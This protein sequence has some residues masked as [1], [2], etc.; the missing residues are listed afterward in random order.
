MALSYFNGGKHFEGGV[1][2]EDVYGREYQGGQAASAYVQ[3][4]SHFGVK[5][6]PVDANQ[7]EQLVILAHGH[8]KAGHAVILSEIDPYC[9][10][11]QRDVLGWSHVVI[12]YAEEAGSITVADPFI[13]QSV[14]KSDAEWAHDLMFG[15]IWIFE[16]IQQEDQ[17]VAISLSTPGVGQYFQEAP[18]GAW[19]CGQYNATI[20]GAILTFYRT[21]G[22]SGLCGLTV[23]GLPTSNEISM[24]VAGHPEIVMQHFEHADVT[25]N[26]NHV[27]GAPPASGPCFLLKQQVR[28]VEVKQTLAQ[29]MDLQR[30][31]T[32]ISQIC[33]G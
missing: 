20:G 11:Y 1:L 26:P 29:V 8:I 28:S 10:A 17:P 27:G 33:K 32:S 25:Y 14:T 7:N 12:A 18:G 15:E 19:H 24:N 23:L 3:L 5:L 2:K 16:K 6:Y 21:L 30:K 4:V 9:T 13:G 31:L 22:N